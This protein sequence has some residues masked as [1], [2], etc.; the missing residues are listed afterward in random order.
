MPVS[1]TGWWTS[2]QVFMDSTWTLFLAFLL[3]NFA[4]INIHAGALE[5]PDFCAEWL[6]AVLG[7]AGIILPNYVVKNLFVTTVNGLV[8]CRSLLSLINQVA[9]RTLFP[10]NASWPCTHC[11]FCNSSLTK[12]RPDRRFKEA[13]LYTFGLGPRSLRAYYKRCDQ[14]NIVIYSSYFCVQTGRTGRQ[15]SVR[16]L[17]QA[18]PLPSDTFV[19]TE[20]TYF[21]AQLFYFLDATIANSNGFSFNG[22]ANSYNDSFN[23]SF[24]GLGR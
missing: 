2:I 23:S 11:P 20:C 12:G 24:R 10:H 6:C 5:D 7:A 1:L 18:Y 14:C 16:H 3:L 13:Y 19:S 22:F 8:G 4:C 9:D 17:G 15:D 21:E